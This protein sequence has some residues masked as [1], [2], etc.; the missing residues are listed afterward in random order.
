MQV[1]HSL[2]RKIKGLSLLILPLKT[3]KE[4]DYLVILDSI[5]DSQIPKILNKL[6]P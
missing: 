5:F 1:L 6:Q 2:E 3:D 4:K